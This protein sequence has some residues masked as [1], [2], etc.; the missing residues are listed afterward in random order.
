[1]KKILDTIFSDNGEFVVR[2]LFAV[3]CMGFLTANLFGQMTQIENYLKTFN[4]KGV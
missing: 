4:K 3:V 2:F 1:M